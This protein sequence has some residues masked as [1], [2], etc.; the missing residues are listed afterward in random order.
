MFWSHDPKCVESDATAVEPSPHTLARR[1]RKVA[2]AISIPICRA[3]SAV[4]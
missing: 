2:L 1:T 3:A 4:R